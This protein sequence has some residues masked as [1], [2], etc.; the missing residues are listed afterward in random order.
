M[1]DDAGAGLEKLNME[2][3]GLDFALI[4]TAADGSRSEIPLSQASLIAL[5]GIVRQT[6][7]YVLARDS[8][9]KLD[10]KGIELQMAIP[11]Q[12]VELNL[13]IHSTAVLLKFL[14]EFEGQSG[15]SLPLR[16]ADSLAEHLPRYVEKLRESEPR[17]GIQ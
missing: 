14:D 16:V 13:N 2:L 6:I 10:Q 9:P 12:A 8:S 15:F 1:E 5:S 7:A 11:V 4:H 3:R 17:H